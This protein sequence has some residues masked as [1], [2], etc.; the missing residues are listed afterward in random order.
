M[1]LLMSSWGESIERDVDVPQRVGMTFS[2][3]G[4]GITIT[5][6]TDFLAFL[7]GVNSTF[8]A[9]RQFC[10]FTGTLGL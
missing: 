9:V 5:T 8:V 7:I 3:A 1:F 2:K 4:I 10:L 6:L